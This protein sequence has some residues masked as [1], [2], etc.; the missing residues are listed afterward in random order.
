MTRVC[1]LTNPYTMSA[2]SVSVFLAKL[3]LS[4][5]RLR[6]RRQN[7]LITGVL[8]N[9]ITLNIC[10]ANIPFL[11]LYPSYSD[12]LCESLTIFDRIRLEFLDQ[13]LQEFHRL[14]DT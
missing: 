6:E 4:Y 14:L 9:L 8:F 11:S 2:T 5:Q 13:K 1:K 12:T 7:L 3:L 10:T